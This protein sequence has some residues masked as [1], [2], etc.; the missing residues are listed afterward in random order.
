[1]EQYFQFKFYEEVIG[2]II[3]LLLLVVV[4]GIPLLFIIKEWIAEWFE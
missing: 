2:T 3:S 4:G 1:M